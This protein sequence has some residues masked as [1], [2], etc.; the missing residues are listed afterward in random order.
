MKNKE[1]Q[2]LNG[3][4]LLTL[5]SLILVTV[6][7]YGSYLNPLFK[8]EKISSDQLKSEVLAYQAAQI[9]LLKNDREKQLRGR[10]IASV[11]NTMT[12]QIGEDSFG[13]PFKF[14]VVSQP[15]GSYQVIISKSVGEESAPDSDSKSGA[16]YS[17][18]FEIPDRD[19]PR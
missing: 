6:G 17:L 9:F 16:A 11:G 5:L 14:D 2:S 3:Y 10:S 15:D 8:S 19:L 4:E 18:K 13:K 12:G 7:T 1:N